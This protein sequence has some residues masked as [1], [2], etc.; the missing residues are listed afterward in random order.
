MKAF[1]FTASYL[2]KGELKYFWYEIKKTAIATEMP[3]AP[4]IKIGDEAKS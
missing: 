3:R 2:F 1:F 4:I